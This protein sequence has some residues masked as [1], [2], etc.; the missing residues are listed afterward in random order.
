[1]GAALLAKHGM[2]AVGKDPAKVFHVTAMVERAPMII[3]GVQ[4]LG[5][6][7]KLPDKVNSDFGDVYKYLRTN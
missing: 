6:P 4:A 3:A 1:M 7:H 5:G 2:V